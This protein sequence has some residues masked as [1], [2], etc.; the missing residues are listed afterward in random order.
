MVKKKG[1]RAN[2]RPF[3]LIHVLIS[4]FQKSLTHMALLPSESEIVIE[5]DK[6]PRDYGA[7]LWRYRELFGFFA[8]RDIIVRYKQATLGVIWALLRPLLNMLAFAFIFGKIAQLP[9]E[10]VS[11]T[12]FVLAGM[13]P[14]QLYANSVVD[15][16]SS[17]V[18]NYQLVSKVYFPR[19]ILPLSQI[20]VYLLDFVIGLCLLI[21]LAAFQHQL[22]WSTICLLPLFIMLALLFC[23]GSALWLSALTVRYRD[24]RLTVPFFIQFGMF[25]SP[26]GYGTFIIPEKWKLLFY[27]N[28]MVGIIDGFRWSLFGI[29]HAEISHTL[30]IS[31]LITIF[32]VIGGAL[33]FR[34]MERSFAD[35]I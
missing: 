21:L 17:L 11:Y 16:C 2:L 10:G 31:T 24:F 14:W 30:I 18:N 22:C 8:W 27:L 32:I 1:N 9:S 29:S 35:Q 25:I 34:R 4:A 12:L 6:L 26:V 13:L 28:P 20:V 7:D 15:T 19:M 3:I 5:A 23:M 33:Y